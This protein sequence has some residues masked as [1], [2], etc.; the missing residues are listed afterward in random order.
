MSEKTM[1]AVQEAQ[2]IILGHTPVMGLERIELLSTLGRVLGEDIAAPFDIPLWDNSAMDGFAVRFQDIET[3]LPDCP[4]HL[5]VIEDLPAGYLPQKAVGPLQATRIMT[6][7]PLPTGADTVVRKEDTV[8]SPATVDI[9]TPPSRGE[10]IRRRG[11]NV[12]QGDLT[13]PRGT[14]LRPG[15]IGLLASFCRSHLA[16]H[17]VPKVAVLATGDEVVAIDGERDQSKLVDSNTYSIAA[18]IKECGAHPLILGIARD[19]RTELQRKLKEGLSADVIV[20]TGGISV[21]D[22]D[23]VREILEGLGVEMR[24]S[25]VAMRP[26]RPAT[27]GTLGDKLVFG[28]PGNPVSCM[29]CFE[30]FVR[31]ALLKMMGYNQVY[32]PRVEA[33]LA[34]D[35]TTKK[36]L[37]FF[38]RVQLTHRDGQVYASATGDQ[39]SGILRSMALA[40]GLLVVPEDREKAH[41]GDKVTVYLLDPL[42]SPLP[43]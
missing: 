35:L 30:L 2:H 13:L 14:V 37:R 36:G 40:K 15:H 16:V 32:R 18:Q 29:V 12:R 17:Q 39:G 23:Y 34:H 41:A 25:K 20:T 26:G 8:S 1:I 19:E 33:V 38:L 28:L 21:G 7:A 24:F 4:V 3:A 27:F 22:Y 6:G 43:L 10:N 42:F 5:T 31:P 11:E 9:L